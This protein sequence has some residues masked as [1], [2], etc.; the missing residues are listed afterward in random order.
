[1]NFKTGHK[2]VV[3]RAFDIDLDAPDVEDHLESLLDGGAYMHRGIDSVRSIRKSKRWVI[4]TSWVCFQETG[5]T[6]GSFR[7]PIMKEFILEHFFGVNGLGIQFPD[8]FCPLPFEVFAFAAIIVSG[9]HSKVSKR[10]HLPHN[11][12]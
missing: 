10:A 11:I 6:V 3:K 7:N 1:M 9:N 2:K 8:E 4:I 5:K 12:D